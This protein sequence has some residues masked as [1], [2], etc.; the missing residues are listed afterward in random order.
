MARLIEYLNADLN[1]ARAF[2]RTSKNNVSCG[3]LN[4]N[5]P[6][7]MPIAWDLLLKAAAFILLHAYNTY[8]Q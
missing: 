8:M 6:D 1:A 5:P 7:G 4:M 2:K 3:M